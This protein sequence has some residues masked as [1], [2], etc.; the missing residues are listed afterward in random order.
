L[1]KD[2]KIKALFSTFTF[3]GKPFIN[4]DVSKFYTNSVNDNGYENSKVTFGIRTSQ[5]NLVF[6]ELNGGY[7]KV[8]PYPIKTK[9]TEKEDMEVAWE[10]RLNPTILEQVA[11][12]KCVRVN[13]EDNSF[14][15]SKKFLIT[16]G[17]SCYDA[18][19]YLKDNLK[20]NKRLYVSGNV[21][22][23]RY[24][25]KQGQWI[26]SIKYIPSIIRLANDDEVD[27]AESKMSFI[28]NK[29]SWDESGLK[30]DGKVIITGYITS[31][32][33]E[34]KQNIFLPLPFVLNCSQ[35]DF[36][37]SDHQNIFNL[38]KDI[39][40]AKVKEYVETAWHS[41]VLRGYEG[42]EISM[43]DLSPNQKLQI[44][45]GMRTFEQIKADMRNSVIRNKVNEIQILA[46][47]NKFE[48]GEPSQ[49]T[50]YEEEDFLIPVEE[51]KTEV[52]TGIEEK[53]N[54][55]ATTQSGVMDLFKPKG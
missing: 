32:E 45:L 25:N 21:E 42:Q 6:V 2:E 27:T 5:N 22:I 34:L 23:S 53:S 41:Y 54:E 30:D 11:G 7:S 13:L 38:Y 51:E 17:N 46:P 55:E 3:I 1:A 52:L 14:D 49:L 28:F 50:V 37:N 35:L 36:S 29:D 40:K 33:K 20:D 15:N 48:N 16:M 39:F 9:N 12:W 24:K 44:K 10:D 31:Y 18:V 8:N 19:Q 47:I 43:D 26:T 4:K